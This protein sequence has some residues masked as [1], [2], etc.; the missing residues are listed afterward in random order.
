[1]VVASDAADEDI[2]ATALASEKVVA[3]LEGLA[4]LKVVVIPGK[5]VSIV[6]K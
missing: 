2:R 3:H 1:V 5:L 6:A 4:V